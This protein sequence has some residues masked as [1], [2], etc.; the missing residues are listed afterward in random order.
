VTQVLDGPQS[1]SGCLRGDAAGLGRDHHLTG[2]VD[3]LS[4][5]VKDLRVLDHM[6]GRG[7]SGGCQ[8]RVRGF[9][10]VVT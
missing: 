2:D 6:T 8:D 9:W 1:D 5:A 3:H 7:R 4:A 10:A